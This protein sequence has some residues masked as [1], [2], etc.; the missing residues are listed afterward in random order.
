MSHFRRQ[1]RADVAAKILTYERFSAFRQI[2]AWVNSPNEKDLPAFAVAIPKTDVGLEADAV[3]FRD[4]TLVVGVKRVG[5][6]ELEDCFDDDAE[7]LELIVFAA[8]QELTSEWFF[9]GDEIAI[10]KEGTKRIGTLSMTFQARV[11]TPEGRPVLCT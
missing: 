3:T 9:V 4:A 8:L 2:P 6:D 5:G 11:Y 7:Q 1:L 10:S